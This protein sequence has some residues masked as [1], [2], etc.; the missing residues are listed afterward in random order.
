MRDEITS[1]FP[2]SNGCTVEV[3]E[4]IS[5]FISSNTSLG[6]WLRIHAA[7]KVSPWLSRDLSRYGYL[8]FVRKYLDLTHR[9]GKIHLKNMIFTC[10]HGT[11]IS[12]FLCTYNIHKL[13]LAKSKS[14][15]DSDLTLL[16]IKFL[17]PELMWSKVTNA[18]WRHREKMRNTACEHCT[19]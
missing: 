1:R 5:T 19:L 18:S 2:N 10:F 12:I 17:L 8:H 15:L 16:A 3:W 11:L 14:G 4:W 6:M 13:L 7:I 9:S